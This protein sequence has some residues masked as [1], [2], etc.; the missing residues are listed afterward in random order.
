M[1]N[2]D[3]KPENSKNPQKVFTRSEQD[4]ETKRQLIFGPELFITEKGSDVYLDRLSVKR[5]LIGDEEEALTEYVADVVAEYE[6]KFSKAWY[7]RLADLY[8]V[9]RSVMDK[10]IKPDFVR[11][12][13]IQFVYA[14]FPNKVLRALR[15]R[16]RITSKD[17]E[18]TKLFQHLTKSASEEL[19]I[20]I[21][22]VYLMMGDCS[23]P[24]EFKMSYS[25]KYKVYF[26]TSLFE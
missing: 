9:N 26:Q 24:F 7:Y 4:L 13:T 2:R 15:R 25:S 18:R 14:R 21:E 19:D 8:S 16:N 11:Q 10:Y 3:Q 5:K 12:F 17:Y 22:Q 23:S 1:A 20:V 6:S